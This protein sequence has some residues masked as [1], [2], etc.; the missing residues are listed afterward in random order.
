SLL[1]LASLS[2]ALA[3]AF[4]TPA[5]TNGQDSQSD[6]AAESAAAE[7]TSPRSDSTADAARQLAEAREALRAAGLHEE[8]RGLDEIIERVSR[9][10]GSKDDDSNGMDSKDG[11]DRRSGG[12]RWSRS[13]KEKGDMVPSEISEVFRSM[14]EISR[15]VED[16][17]A[18]IRELRERYQELALGESAPGD[19]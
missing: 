5:L 12:W 16:H 4:Q 19:G 9:D 18:R 15:G 10:G 17:E 11:D 8:A 3:V 6:P 2:I 7:S 13:D 1:A 14:I